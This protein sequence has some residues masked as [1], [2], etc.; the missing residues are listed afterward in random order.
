MTGGADG[1]GAGLFKVAVEGGAPI[2][3]TSGVALNPVWNPDGSMIVYNGANM[4]GWAPL[5]AV[6]P[7]GT[8]VA[9]PDINVQRDGERVRFLPSGKGL[10]YAQGVSVSSQDFWLLDL[11]TKKSRR[12]TRLANTAATRAFDITPDG[13]QIVFDRLRG[14]SDIALIDLAGSGR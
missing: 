2:R 7:D 3:L 9:L 4:G 8:P 6:R 5:R 1:G 11:A 12:L 10:V 13:T 14:T